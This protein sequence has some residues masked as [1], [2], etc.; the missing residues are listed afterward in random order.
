MPWTVERRSHKRAASKVR[1]GK[2]PLDQKKARKGT[3][4]AKAEE[5]EKPEARVAKRAKKVKENAPSKADPR[6]VRAKGK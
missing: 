5:K 1:M 2:A 3:S 6:G 4:K